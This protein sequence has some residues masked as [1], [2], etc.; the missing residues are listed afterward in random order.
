MVPGMADVAA[1]LLL[2]L[3]LAYLTLAGWRWAAGR[4][5]RATG[6]NLCLI[7]SLRLPTGPT[8]HLVRAGRRI[9]LVQSSAQQG[10]TVLAELA[11]EEIN[12][13]TE[14]LRPMARNQLLWWREFRHVALRNLKT[15]GA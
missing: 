4:G 2:V 11:K 13:A 8:L 10:A 9:F 1:K 15:G 14:A 7:E 12:E 5:W 6:R 3:A